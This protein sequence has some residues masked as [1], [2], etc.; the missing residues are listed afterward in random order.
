[1]YM[2]VLYISWFAG[3]ISYIYKPATSSHLKPRFFQMTSLTWPSTDSRGL[4]HADPHSSRLANLGLPIFPSS[5]VH[6]FMNSSDSWSSQI[7]D[8]LISSDSIRPE[9]DNRSAIRR[10]IRRS[11]RMMLENSR[12]VQNQHYFFTNISMLW[13]ILSA[14]MYIHENIHKFGTSTFRGWTVFDQFP[15]T[16]PSG[17]RVDSDDPIPR[18]KPRISV[19]NVTLGTSE[20]T[21]VPWKLATVVSRRFL[22]ATP[23]L[24]I[25]RWPVP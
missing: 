12:I 7:H 9:T 23:F 24:P 6:V 8:S 25:N 10:S 19:K 1:M 16:S 15:N 18:I 21:R 2:N 4:I 20:W 14:L 17:K 5:L 11:S 22:R 13:S 3:L